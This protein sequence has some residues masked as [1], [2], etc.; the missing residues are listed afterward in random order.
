MQELCD[1]GGLHLLYILHHIHSTPIS[2]ITFIFCATAVQINMESTQGI[3]VSAYVH[4]QVYTLDGRTMGAHRISNIHCAT[5]IYTAHFYRH[6]CIHIQVQTMNACTCAHTHH[7]THA[8]TYMHAHIHASTGTNKAH[9]TEPGCQ[10][11]GCLGVIS[12]ENESG[13]TIK[14]KRYQTGCPIWQ[15]M[16]IYFGVIQRNFL[17]FNPAETDVISLTNV[18]ITFIWQ[19]LYSP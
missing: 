7:A 14:Q 5:G 16:A 8:H 13:H 4:T 2:H 18:L 3:L 9:Y 15:N 6:V 17:D 11:K 19:L 12:C 10:T 1:G